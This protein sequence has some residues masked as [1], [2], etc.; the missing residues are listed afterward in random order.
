[1]VKKILINGKIWTENPDMEWAE[2]IAIDEDKFV[3]VGSNDEVK[4]FVEAQDGEF[5]VVD[6]E[7]KTVLP[8]FI[9]AH[10]HPGI[11]ARG[12]WVVFGPLTEDK[13][14][15]FANIERLSKKYPKEE[16]PYFCYARYMS[17]TF[18][19]EGPHSLVI[20]SAIILT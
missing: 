7:G 16:R 5:E 11:M 12:L 13:D 4:S 3:A 20:F 15:L 1:M 18:G 6:L 17:S 10:T 19:S 8:G 14:E 9:D 2:A